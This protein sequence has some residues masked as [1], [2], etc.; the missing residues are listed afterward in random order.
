MARIAPGKHKRKGLS[1]VQVTDLFH[2]HAAA[3]KWIESQIWPDGLY[4]PNSWIVNIQTLRASIA[5]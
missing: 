4:C 3:R 1:I 2:D 5:R